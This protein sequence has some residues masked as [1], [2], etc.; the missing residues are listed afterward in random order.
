MGVFLSKPSITKFSED[1]DDD[2]VRFGVS[3][4]Q[5]WRRGM[6]DAHL[7]LLDVKDEAAEA[8]AA[9]EGGDGSDKIRIFGVF[10]GHGGKEVAL[11]VQE[12]MV[13][14]LVKL[15]E[16]R[17]GDYPGALARVFHRMD[18]LLEAAATELRRSKGMLPEEGGDI[19]RSRGV[20]AGKPEEEEE[21]GKEGVRGEGKGGGDADSSGKEGEGVGKAGE[22]DVG[23]KG[24]CGEG[25]RLE[26]VS[27]ERCKE[28][29]RELAEFRR[30]HCVPSRKNPSDLEAED[31]PSKAGKPMLGSAEDDS[32]SDED[33]DDGG[34]GTGPSGRGGSR[35]GDGDRVDASAVS[36]KSSGSSSSSSNSNG[37]G[38]GGDDE[39]VE[40]G[41]ADD[42]GG[43]GGASGAGRTIMMADALELF[44]RIL[45]IRKDQQ[46]QQQQQ[47]RTTVADLEEKEE[48]KGGG[49]A[50]G[51]AALSPSDPSSTVGGGDDSDASPCPPLP[52]RHEV[53][54]SVAGEKK[55]EEDVVGRGGGGDQLAPSAAGIGRETPPGG[56]GYDDDGAPSAAG[57]GDSGTAAWP[58]G[59]GVGDASS[60]PLAVAVSGVDEEGE[61]TF[62]DSDE[63]EEDDVLVTPANAS[64]NGN[65]FGGAGAG[66]RPRLGLGASLASLVHG[67]GGDAPTCNLQDHPIQAGCTSVVC[68]MV[69]KNLHV[70]NAG[71]SRAVL[72]RAGVAVALSHDHKPLADTEKNRIERAGGFVNAAG[73]VNGNLN[74]SRSIGDLKYK[75]NAGLPPADQMITAEPDLKSVEVTNEDQ[76]MILACDGVWDCMSSQE[77]V[78]FVGARVRHMS[79]SKVCEEVMEACLSEDPRSTTGIGGDNMTCI[80]VLLDK[81]FAAAEVL[82]SSS[83][84][85]AMEED[86]EDAAQGAAAAEPAPA[87][88]SSED[89][90]SFAGGAGAT[91]A[92]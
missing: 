51:A 34:E 20:F 49:G 26:E 59:G 41:G 32:D 83:G 50:T 92:E 55:K 67:S 89:N 23:V 91:D 48:E 38:Y 78:D 40:L 90:A 33:E 69:G 85:E 87:P 42:N 44:H 68:L 22:G 21:E 64:A 46:Q 3:S 5:G 74:L 57:S 7:A 28:I 75:A 18:E 6:E 19:A 79:L 71:D 73:R 60:S 63:S 25:E 45:D 81:S 58:T 10:D 8:V 12:H 15:Q 62:G 1:G 66:A 43:A 70:A 11:F 29:L 4:M 2:V 24:G 84:E 27:I 35:G 37:S 72:C 30:V 61:D 39:V 31:P 86:V 9:G 14:E 36:R 80:V 54:S 17:A 47:P 82:A 56:S 52:D 76:F 13:E 53:G 16:Y 77:C 65:P 88:A